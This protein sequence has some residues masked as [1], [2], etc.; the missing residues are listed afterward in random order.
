M[1]HLNAV[2]MNGG[3]GMVNL[4]SFIVRKSGRKENSYYIDYQGL[5]TAG[6]IARITG[7]ET[8]AVTMIYI[9]HGAEYD[10]SQQVYYFGSIESAKNAVNEI[11]SNVRPELK[12]KVL[13][14]T[15]AEVEYIR[16]A[17]IN[18]GSNTIYLKSK[19]KDEIF[20]KLNE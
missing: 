4:S 1:V 10:G 11:F 19:I 8:A 15:E 5:Y 9:H 17:L 12:G 14:L 3:A 20:R 7:L 16:R 13:H 18:E 2:S 6:D